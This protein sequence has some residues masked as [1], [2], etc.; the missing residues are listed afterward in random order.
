MSLEGKLQ[1]LLCSF[2]LWGTERT[3]VS[4]PVT[5]WCESGPWSAGSTMTS[6]SSAPDWTFSFYCD[7]HRGHR[8]ITAAQ[9]AQIPSGCGDADAHDCNLGKSSAN[10]R[11]VCECVW[12]VSVRLYTPVQ[13]RSR[14]AE[15]GRV[16]DVRSSPR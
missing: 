15:I 1:V 10:N 3:A 11:C 8:R 5:S 9:A 2:C 14:A 7:I 12:C 6:P 16:A 13:L 4:L